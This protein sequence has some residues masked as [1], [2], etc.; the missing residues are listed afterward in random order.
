MKTIAQRETDADFQMDNVVFLIRKKSMQAF[1]VFSTLWLAVK[2][3]IA[4]T[5]IQTKTSLSIS[6]TKGQ[7]DLACNLDLISNNYKRF[8]YV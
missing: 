4:K 8:E 6:H 2:T 1:L 3:K 5:S 7:F